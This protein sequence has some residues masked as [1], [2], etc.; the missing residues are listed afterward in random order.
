MEMD[1]KSEST[2]TIV[3]PSEDELDEIKY[4]TKIERPILGLRLK[5]RYFKIIKLI[6][7][8]ENFN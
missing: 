3:S 4:E 5:V 1:G 8:T 6:I 2:A 7:I